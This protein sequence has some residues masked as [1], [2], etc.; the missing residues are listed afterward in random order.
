VGSSV[1]TANAISVAKGGNFIVAGQKYGSGPG[2]N[3]VYLISVIADCYASKNVSFTFKIDVP[4]DSLDYGYKLINV[5]LG[6]A[7][8]LGGTVS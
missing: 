8:S 2:N 1:A 5:P 6:M 7:V 3:D 4:G